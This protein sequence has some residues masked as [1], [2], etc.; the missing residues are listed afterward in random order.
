MPL[1]ARAAPPSSA[2]SPCLCDTTAPLVQVDVLRTQLGL[3][4]ANEW[5]PFSGLPD[6]ET[7]RQLLDAAPIN[8]VPTR[9]HGNAERLALPDDLAPAVGGTDAKQTST[10]AAFGNVLKAIAHTDSPFAGRIVTACPDVTT[11]TGLS[12]FVNKRGVFTTGSAA[13]DPFKS[14][15]AHSLSNW[16]TRSD[17]Q[18]IE[19]GI[20]ENNLCLLLAA[21]GLSAPLFG[22][23]LFPI[24]QCMHHHSA[25]S[26]FLPLPLLL[27]CSPAQCCCGRKR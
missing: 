12:G 5:E 2:S 1:T 15:K 21:F 6:G 20:A 9:S 26:A 13:H 11:T 14:A 23:R 4:A 3:T 27:R 16:A 8:R 7:A 22:H 10:Q 18:H 24:G 25:P 17:G 19:L